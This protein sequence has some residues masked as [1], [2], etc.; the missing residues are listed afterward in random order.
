MPMFNKKGRLFKRI[1][2]L[3]LLLIVIII[4]LII[5]GFT[6]LSKL[7]REGVIASKPIHLKIKV[8]NR[9]AFLFDFIKDKDIVKEFDTGTVLG[10]IRRIEVIPARRN[11]VTSDGQ[12]KHAQIPERFDLLIEIH[13]EAIVTHESIISGNSHLKI[14]GKLLLR[15]KTYALDST[16]LD[17]TIIEE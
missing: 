11:V 10:E 16:I 12:I 15:T 4:G 9:E 6:K 13:G 7:N 8:T 14:G 3:D 1:N 17:L 2:I 5:G